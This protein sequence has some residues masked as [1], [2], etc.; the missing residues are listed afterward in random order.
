MQL[1]CQRFLLASGLAIL[2]L[3]TGCA[4]AYKP[5]ENAIKNIKTDDGQPF[6]AQAFKFEEFAKSP[7][8]LKA[9]L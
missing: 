4:S 2:V 7:E 3:L 9:R 1:N 8:R 6:Y 5:T